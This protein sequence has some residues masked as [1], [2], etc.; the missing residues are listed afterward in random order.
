MAETLGIYPNRGPCGSGL[1]LNHWDSRGDGDSSYLMNDF[2]VLGKLRIFRHAIQHELNNL[3][4]LDSRSGNDNV[5]SRNS[6]EIN[7]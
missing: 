1:N 2:T 5:D 7:G 6:L 4:L 3:G